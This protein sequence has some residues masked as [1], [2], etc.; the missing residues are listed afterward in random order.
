M[1]DGALETWLP[2]LRRLP[3][4]DPEASAVVYYAQL[5]RGGITSA[6]HLEGPT[7]PED[8]VDRLRGVADGARRVGARIAIAVPLND[9]GSTLYGHDDRATEE[10]I[11]CGYT[12]DPSG[13]IPDRVVPA[14]EQVALVDEV[15]ANVEGDGVTVQLGPL[16]PQWVSDEL[17][18][19]IAENSRRNGRRVHM[20]LLESPA[21]RAAADADHPDGVIRHLD[22]LGVLSER[23]SVAHGVWLRPDEMELLADRSVT[24][25]VNPSS[26]LRLRSGISPAATMVRLGVRV[27]TGL[28]GITLDDDLDGWREARLFHLL[29]VGTAMTDGLSRADAFRAGMDHA[30]FAVTGQPGPWG[31]EPGSPADA[32]LLDR[33]RMFHDVVDERL[34][35]P[36]SMILARATR[37]HVKHVIAGGRVVVRD[38]RLT[39]SDVADAT[40]MLRD[41]LSSAAA[42]LHHGAGDLADFQAALRRF[43]DVERVGAPQD[44]K[45]GRR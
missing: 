23:L 28:D 17:M 34:A 43:Y 33:E 29:N 10:L 31:F 7:T 26:N 38:G 40:A 22:R 27:A 2:A 42:Q 18:V 39:T 36:A 37:R 21:Q 15:A 19:A 32:V 44:E 4:L 30:H 3:A 24:V 13:W 41:Q 45:L 5:L 1:A 25:V 16:G 14:Q 20:H 12:G 6:M 8:M 9:R 35:D 11:G